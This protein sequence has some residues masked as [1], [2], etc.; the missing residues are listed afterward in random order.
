MQETTTP[1]PSRSFLLI[2]AALVILFWGLRQAEAFLVPLLLA[3]LVAFA[4]APLMR[5]LKRL[6][7]PE[8]ACIVCTALLVV[9]PL[10]TMAVLAVTE[11]QKLVQDWPHLQASLLAAAERLR[12]VEWV[13]KY[14]LDQYLDPQGL[15]DRAGEVAGSAVRIVLDGLM[16]VFSAGTRMVLVLFFAIVMVAT[17]MHLRKATEFAV[18]RYSKNGRGRFIDD[19]ASTIEAFLGA[20]IA[21]TGVTGALGLVVGLAFGLPYAFLIFLFYGIMTW[22]PT[23]G[24]IIAIL[25]PLAVAIAVGKSP[26]QIVAMLAILIGIWAMQD[27]ILTPKWMGSK[28]RLNFLA[29]YLALFGGA[30]LWGAWGMFL[31]V[32]LLAVLRIAFAASPDLLPISYALSDDEEP[33]PPSA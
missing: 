17:R 12:G 9:V 6:K 25:P 23:I 27:H 22:V 1:N 33:S 20:R 28:L 14:G 19:V 15:S 2:A 16:Q 3:G 4:M 5:I 18:L 8:W 29:T 7:L 30:Q 24:M 21:I 26:G 13:Q 31:G 10:L 11:I 32:P